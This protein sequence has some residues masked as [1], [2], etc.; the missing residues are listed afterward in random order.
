MGLRWARVVGDE[1]GRLGG[2]GLNRNQQS[3]LAAVAPDEGTSRY[4]P[5][6]T[7][8]GAGG[9]GG[10]QVSSSRSLEMHYSS[11]PLLP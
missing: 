4:L 7:R 8:S 9:P 6:Q 10:E 3:F 2:S 1:G 5:I 11:T